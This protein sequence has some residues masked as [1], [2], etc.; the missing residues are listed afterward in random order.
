MLGGVFN[1][2]EVQDEEKQQTVKNRKQTKREVDYVG[3]TDQFFSI[4]RINLSTNF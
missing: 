2:P 3:T 1:S 4:P